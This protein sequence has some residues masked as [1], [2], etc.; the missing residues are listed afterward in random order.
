MVS[1]LRTTFFITS[2]EAMVY[3]AGYE[4]LSSCYISDLENPRLSDIHM[5]SAIS[6]PDEKRL[7]SQSVE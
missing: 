4:V 5:V 6:V 2:N 3:Q 7:G 1:T